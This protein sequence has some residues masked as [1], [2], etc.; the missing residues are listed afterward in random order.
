MTSGVCIFISTRVFVG[1]YLDNRHSGIMWPAV[2]RISLQAL[3]DNMRIYNR[4]RP[5]ISTRGSVLPA[6]PPSK[7]LALFSGMQESSGYYRT[8]G[9]LFF[10]CSLSTAGTRALQTNHRASAGPH[11]CP[12]PMA[13]SS[14]LRIDRVAHETILFNP[15]SQLRPIWG[16]L[17]SAGCV[18]RWPG[19]CIPKRAIEYSLRLRR[20][21]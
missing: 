4:R 10:F 13:I 11:G 21:V 20:A 19:V 15:M 18:A 16:P 9:R 12:Y 14:S 17:H 2:R 1:F 3:N 8:T 5:E 6:V 7:P